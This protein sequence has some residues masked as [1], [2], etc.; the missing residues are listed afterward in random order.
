VPAIA[1]L[2]RGMGKCAEYGRCQ[3]AVVG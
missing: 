2:T 1:K 3:G